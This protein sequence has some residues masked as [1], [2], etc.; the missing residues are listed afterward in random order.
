MKDSKASL[1]AMFHFLILNTQGKWCHNTSYHVGNI[2]LYFFSATTVILY[3]NKRINLTIP[4]QVALHGPAEAG[5][6]EQMDPEVL[7]HLRH[8]E[9]RWNR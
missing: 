1:T 4:G 7:S 5:G 8:S 6:L 2:F 9:V 3:K